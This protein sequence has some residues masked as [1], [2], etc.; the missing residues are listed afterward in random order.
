MILQGPA[1]SWYILFH[2]HIGRELLPGESVH[3]KNGVSDDN[4][5]ENLELWDTRQPSGQRV[6][7]KIA[8][9]KA[10]LIEHGYR[11]ADPPVD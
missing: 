9:A 6:V 4:R 3:H 5:I 1:V 7:D 2:E 10:Y 8:W 11:V